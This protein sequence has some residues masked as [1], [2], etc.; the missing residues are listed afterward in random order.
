MGLMAAADLPA[1]LPEL[2]SLRSSLCFVLGDQDKWIPRAQLE[3]VIDRWAPSARRED[4]PGGHLL[5]EAD[6][7]RCAAL[8][9]RHLDQSL[10]A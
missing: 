6:P 4:W 10:S 3:S 7:N 2:A 1:L 5:H 8:I 9:Q